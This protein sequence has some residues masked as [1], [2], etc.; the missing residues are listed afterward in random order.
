[1]PTWTEKPAFKPA[2]L[3]SAALLPL[4]VAAGS[5]AAPPPQ[6]I[7]ESPENESV[8]VRMPDD[9]L[10]IFFVLRPE[11]SEIW[12]IE[13]TDH[14]MTWD[15]PAHEF[16]I[17]AGEAYYGLIVTVDQN[18]ELQ[19]L[20]HVRSEGPHGRHGRHYD[21]W[22]TR[23]HDGLSRW[24]GQQMIHHGYTG[25]FRGFVTLESGRLLASI[26][27]SRPDR[28]TA[29]PPPEP[30]LGWN[31]AFVL[32]SDDHGAT[33]DIG[34]D[35]LRFAQDRTRGR[36]RNGPS[37]PHVHQ[38]A[39]G[40]VW[41]LIRSKNGHFY[42]TFS[43]DD[44]TTWPQPRRSRFVSSDSPAWVT[45]LSD[46]RIVLFFNSCQ[47]WD[48]LRGY[49]IGGRDVLHAAIS[50][51]EGASWRGFREVWHDTA[52]PPQR[53]DRGTAYPMAVEA[54]DGHIVMIGGQGEG[55]RALL[56]IDPDWLGEETTRATFGNETHEWTFI[57]SRGA[58][59][60]DHPDS[61][62]AGALHVR[63]THRELT[64]SAVWNFPMAESGE[65][66]L[67]IRP[68]EGWGGGLASL[69]DHYCAAGDHLAEENAVYTIRL[70]GDGDLRAGEWNDIVLRWS[71]DFA[72]IRINGG[73]AEQLTPLRDP[74]FGVNYLRLR[75]GSDTVDLRGFLVDSAEASIH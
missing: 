29:P 41:M 48:D 33:W 20:F 13:S 19:C 47:R 55:R 24:G 10:R 67:R 9:S 27:S 23:T 66:R 73:A 62:G 39:D 56:R 49:A 3:L 60:V 38:L 57:D 26:I 64:G 69:T 71:P 42:E 72:S 28:S 5:G 8:I 6:F 75:P 44:G 58:E 70:D 30:D 51:D 65:L 53:G 40:T 14:G 61:P 59:L 35:M 15:E 74:G 2:A 7:M 1:M 37:E 16:T 68:L 52:P 17:E 50:D 43:H 4:A 21:V 54:A 32:T 12:S 63:R 36:T 22:H 45:R 31:D 11:G 18:G 25:S 46:G 34:D